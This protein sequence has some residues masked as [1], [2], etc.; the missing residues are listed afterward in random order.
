[1]TLRELLIDNY[2]WVTVLI[3]FAL[4]FS[5]ELVTVFKACRV[6]RWMRRPSSPTTENTITAT[7]A[8]T[9]SLDDDWA[10]IALELK[11]ENDHA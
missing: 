8:A 7:D 5:S 3:A 9:S 6:L 11:K 10:D 4:V 2:G 1:M